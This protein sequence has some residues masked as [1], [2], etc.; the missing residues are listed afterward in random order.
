MMSISS[1]LANAKQVKSEDWFALHR[2]CRTNRIE[3][4]SGPIGFVSFVC[5]DHSQILVA[6]IVHPKDSGMTDAPPPAY[7]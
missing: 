2:K 5:E 1:R 3:S 6:E 4:T 7:P